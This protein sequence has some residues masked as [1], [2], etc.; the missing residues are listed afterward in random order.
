MRLPV[1]IVAVAALAGSLAAGTARAGGYKFT[2]VD[3]PAPNNGGT[4]LAGINN[5]GVVAGVTYDANDNVRAFFGRPSGAL[6]PLGL[7]YAQAAFRPYQAVISGINDNGEI[8][9]YVPVNR[10]THFEGF[11]FEFSDGELVPIE[12]PWKL[13]G[14]PAR[15][16]NNDDVIA[17]SFS[18]GSKVSAY[19]LDVWNNLTAFDATPWTNWTAAVG[20]NNKGT[21]VGQYAAGFAPGM[22]T[23]GFL[24]H[25]D[26]TITLLPAPHSIGGVAVGPNGIYYTGINDSGATVGSFLDPNNHSYGFVRDAAG[27]FTLIQFPGAAITAGVIGINNS[28]TIVGNYF[29]QNSVE[30]GFIATPY[31]AH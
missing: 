17:G 5:S 1:H 8:L 12:V 26:G 19:T 31:V 9:G 7:P 20:I 22:V 11:M 27:N 10:R 25:A 6:I 2:T 15:S 24:R 30:H 23:A 14:A 13:L 4:Q 28:G 29:D 21:V 3:G 18:N 16:M